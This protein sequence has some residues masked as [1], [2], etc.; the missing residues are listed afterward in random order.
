MKP[1][2]KLNAALLLKQ[3]GS[4]M[5]MLMNAPSALALHGLPG[6]PYAVGVGSGLAALGTPTL[7]DEELEEMN[8]RKARALIPGVRGY[9]AFKRLGKTIN[10]ERSGSKARGNTWGELLSGYTNPLALGLAGAGVGA[11]TGL[12]YPGVVFETENKTPVEKAI[13]GA[14]VG[15]VAGVGAGA[16]GSIAGLIRG[17]GE[18]RKRNLEEQAEYDSRSTA[19]SSLLVPGSGGLN[20]MRR[21]RATDSLT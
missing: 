8:R 1:T 10:D 12:T 9:R 5:D 3:A 20:Y 17:I 11:L 4:R 21:L 19:L 15:G 16:V 13:M 18:R 2:E 7:T 6:V 14:M